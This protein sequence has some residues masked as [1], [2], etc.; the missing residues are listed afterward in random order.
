MLHDVNGRGHELIQAEGGEKGDQLIP[1]LYAVGV[2][3]AL[4]AA[5]SQLQPGEELIAFLDH[6]YMVSRQTAGCQPWKLMVTAAF[7][8]IVR[9]FVIQ[10]MRP[11]SL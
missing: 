6:T 5:H 2:H 9:A 10:F 7:I 11:L 3:P 4:Q 1:R 8:H